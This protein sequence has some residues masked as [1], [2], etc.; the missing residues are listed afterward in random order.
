RVVGRR[1]RPFFGGHPELPGTSP[2]AAGPHVPGPSRMKKQLC[3]DA[4]CG[5]AVVLVAGRTVGFVA[6]FAIPIVL[7]RVFS[8]TE[9]GTYKQ[10]F[11]LF[12]TLYGVAQLGVAESLYF[13][14]PRHVGEAGKHVCNALV[15]LA[16]AGLAC[17]AALYV[18]RRQIAAWLTNSQ[19]ADQ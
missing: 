15:T 18:T 11:L 8:P 19:L 17:L 6:V 5:P 9:F 14:I 2:L 4:L 12:A 1:R 13:F 3:L 16:F 10:L 7:A